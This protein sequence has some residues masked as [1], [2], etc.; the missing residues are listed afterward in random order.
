MR[1]DLPFEFN[2]WQDVWLVQ[3]NPF[4]VILH[5]FHYHIT[6]DLAIKYSQTLRENHGWKAWAGFF[7]SL[8]RG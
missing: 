1:V 6:G 7:Q 5:R 2:T 3:K 4:F 8:R